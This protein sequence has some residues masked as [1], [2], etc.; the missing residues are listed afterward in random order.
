MA[1]A[2]AVEA[3]V[4]RIHWEDH[5]GQ[6]LVRDSGARFRIVVA[7][8]Q[9]GKTAF[10]VIE[11]LREHGRR[12][13]AALAQHPPLW[14]PVRIWH[15]LPNYPLTMEAV[16]RFE[17][18]LPNKLIVRRNRQEHWVELPDGS[19]YQWKSADDPDS[20]R[21]AGVDFLIVDEAAMVSLEAWHVLLPTLA[22][23]KGRVLIISTPKGGGWFKDKYTQGK[24]TDNVRRGRYESWQFTSFDNPHLDEETL[25][26]IAVNLTED[27]LAQELEAQFITGEGSVFKSIEAICTARP[28]GPIPGVRYI[29]GVDWGRKTDSSAIAVLDPARR[30]MVHVEEFSRGSWKMVRERVK[31]RA[32]EYNQALVVADDTGIGDPVNE[33]FLRIYP[34]LERVLIEQTNKSHFVEHLVILMENGDVELLDDRTLKA[35][36]ESYE[37]RKSQTGRTTVYEAPQGKHDDEV[38]ATF[39]AVSKLGRTWKRWLPWTGKGRRRVG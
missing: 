17:Q 29:M 32:E 33:E 22:A 36:L 5:P 39:L 28:E 15:V 25:N 30:R 31:M 24:D 19:L 8:R 35:Q 11:A 2:E 4:E 16:L 9:W 20:L 37:K 38:T 34:R 12:A 27:M 10:A 13:P 3:N 7:G 18:L 14:P 1:V 6:A 21:G 23:R 26:E